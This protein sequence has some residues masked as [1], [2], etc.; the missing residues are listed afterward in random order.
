MEAA[1]QAPV[2][3]VS[4]TCLPAALIAA[5]MLWAMPA[6]AQTDAPKPNPAPPSTQQAPGGKSLTDLKPK[7]IDADIDPCKV[8]NPPSYCGKH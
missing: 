7:S 6:H 3:Y 1:M 8:K 5:A 2:R 4:T